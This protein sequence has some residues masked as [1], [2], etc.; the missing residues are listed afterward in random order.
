MES[1]GELGTTVSAT[2]A[3]AAAVA[4]MDGRIGSAQRIERVRDARRATVV[5]WEWTVAPGDWL[6]SSRCRCATA[7]AV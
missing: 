3:T 6:V 1:D 5:G 7:A 2:T 4:M